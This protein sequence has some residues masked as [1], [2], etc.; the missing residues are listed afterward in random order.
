MLNEINDR[1]G[2]KAGISEKCIYEFSSNVR[3]AQDI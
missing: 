2:I 3:I 1:D